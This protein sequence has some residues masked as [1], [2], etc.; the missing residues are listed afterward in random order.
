MDTLSRM[1]GELPQDRNKCTRNGLILRVVERVIHYSGVNGIELL[2]VNCR[3]HDDIYH[4]LFLLS[5][6]FKQKMKEH[7]SVVMGF[8]RY[9]EVIS[10]MGGSSTQWKEWQ[11]RSQYDCMCLW[12][13]NHN[14]RYCG[15]QWWQTVAITYICVYL[16]VHTYT[17]MHRHA[18]FQYVFSVT[19]QNSLSQL[20][21]LSFFLSQGL[22]LFVR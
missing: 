7:F 21:N 22:I 13:Q 11:T 6:L 17:H 8:L 19:S 15:Q 14:Y 5:P 2:H 18:Q 3:G 20:F 10:Y 4:V 1:I 16:C 9:L 12:H